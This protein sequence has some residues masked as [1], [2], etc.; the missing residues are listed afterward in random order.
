EL[1]FSLGLGDHVVA[2]DVTATFEQARKLPL[3]TRAHDVSA[4]NVLS[5]HPTLVL[6]ESTTGPAEAIEQ[7]RDAGVPLVILDPAKSLD[8]VDTRIH[9]VAR[10]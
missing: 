8:D 1:V 10:T 2:K 6:A 4:E 7:I 5:L 3:V 9:A